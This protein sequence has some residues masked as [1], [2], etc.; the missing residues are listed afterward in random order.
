MALIVLLCIFFCGRKKRRTLID[1]SVERHE[2][3]KDL[4]KE[5]L[6]IAIPITI[7]STIMP[8]MMIIDLSVIMR[9]LQ[10][11]GWSLAESKTLYGLISGFCD[12]L[13]GLPGVFIDAVSMSLLPAV[14]AAFV[15]KKKEEL[16]KTVQTGIKTMM[17]VAYPCA[18]GLIVL[19]KPILHM[20]YPMRLEEADMAVT[21]LQILSLSILTLSAMRTFSTTLQAVGKMVLP[22]FNLFIGAIVK[23]V[24]SYILVGIPALNINGAAIGSVSAYLVAGLLNYRAMKKYAGAKIDL[25]GTFVRPLIASG[26]MGVATYLVYK[27]GMIVIGRNSIA[28]LL[29]IVVAVV[30]YF[31][32]I[33]ITKTMNRED[34]LMLPGGRRIVKLSD[35]LH[36]TSP[37]E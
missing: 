5:L 25:I 22:V 9:R 18:I 37:G 4:F 28:T 2:T 20:M 35:K 6:E 21:N 17:V 7:G 3:K 11:T 1:S 15:L 27:V 32:M 31:F 34:A 24:L 33:F 12:P 16:D 13:I 29:A 30:V 23:I 8:L 14:T 26:I 36:L 19:A 10:A